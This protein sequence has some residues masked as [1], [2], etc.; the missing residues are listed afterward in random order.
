MRINPNLS[1]FYDKSPLRRLFLSLLIVLAGGTILF[2]LFIIAWNILSDG[3]LTLLSGQSTDL[4]LN[5]PGFIKFALVAQDISYFIVPALIIMV[6]L[7][8][9]YRSGILNLNN[10]RLTEV[11]F[12][13]ILSFCAFPV[14]GLAGELN[15]GMVLPDWLSGVEDWM[16]DKEAYA[17]HMMEAI[18]TPESF[19]G[20]LL[21][22]TIIAVLPAIGE[23]LIFRG[24]FQNIFQALFRS[25]H[26]AVWITSII[27]SAVHLQ[28]YGFL[29]RLILGL[30]FGYLF[31]WTNSIWLPVLAHFINNAVPTAGAFF[32]GAE[33][34]NEPSSGSIANQI[35]G[36][37]VPFVV[38][39]LI[40]AWFRQR[41][42]GIRSS[43]HEPP[44]QIAP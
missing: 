15:S 1:G 10:L 26:L 19:K 30:I 6:V 12:V 7:D 5:A 21:N 8:P 2:S 11:L 41:S 16:K 23:E 31:L 40:L 42:K 3:G 44:E 43:D 18:M 25:G 17:D 34:I 13:V 32:R 37:I 28:F 39:I 33:A 24:V 9:G 36:A 27:F 14:T 38:G 20:M 4:L 29:P 22:I 35:P